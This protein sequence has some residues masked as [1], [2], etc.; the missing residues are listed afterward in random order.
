[1]TSIN[2]PAG[3]TS[4]GN[5]AFAN[6]SGLISLTNM[7]PQPV[8]INNNVFE[9]VNQSECELK[10]PTSSVNAYQNANVW[11][12]FY[13]IGENYTI[14]VIA[15]KGNV[16][17]GGMYN[18]NDSATLTAT[19]DL[20]YR[21]AGWTFRT[22]GGTPVSTANPFT[23]N[24]TIDTVI[25]A[26]FEAIAYGISYELNGGV[27]HADNPATYTVEDSV[28]LK[29]PTR[30][31]YEF[32][33]WAEGDTIVF[34]STGDRTFTAQWT[35]VNIFNIVYELNGG[36]NHSDNPE[37]YTVNDSVRLKAPTKA[38]YD[39]TGWAEG[40]RIVFGSTGDK[41]FTATWSLITYG[42][43]YELNG[44]VN[45]PDNPST[46][47]IEDSV[48]LKTP[49]KP[50][51]NFAG[52]AGDTIAF[53]GTGDKTLTAGWSAIVYNISY[54]LN[55]GVNHPD[56]PSTYTVED[57]VILKAPTKSGYNFAGWQGRDTLI[58]NGAGDKTFIAVWK[59]VVY[60]IIYEL[61]GGVNHTDNPAVYTIE[62]SVVMK[63]PVREGYSFAGWTGD[64]V[65][66]RGSTGDK[67]VTAQWSIITYSII[68]ELDGGTNH[69]ENPATY[70]VNDTVVIKAPTKP[71]YNFAGWHGSDTVI[72]NGTGDRTYTVLWKV[73]VY[74]IDYELDGGEN[75]VGNPA[76]YT[77]ED[78]VILQNPDRTGYEFTGWTEG[79]QIDRGSTGD[80][81][82]TATWKII[83]YSIIYELDGGVNHA[84]NP[85][86]CT[87]NDSVTLKAPSKE[88][89]VFDGWKEGGSIS[90]GSTGD[91]TFTA[92][93]KCIEA[94][95]EE[96]V[97]DG[98]DITE[99]ANDS[100][101]E[102]TV[103]ECDESSVS[104]D[105]GS[106]SQSN[107]TVNGETYA[108]GTEITLDGDLTTV[109]IQVESETGDSVKNYTLK[110]AAPI[111]SDNLY[112]QRWNDVIAVNRNPATNGGYSVS[113]VRWYSQNGSFAGAGEYITLSNAENVN[114]Y[115]S[116][117]KTEETASWHRVCAT[118]ETKSIEKVTAYPNPVPRGENITLHLP[119]RLVGSVLN[120]YSITGFLVKSGLPLPASVNSID[121]SSLDSGIYLL[122]ILNKDGNRHVIRII[123]E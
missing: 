16:T 50:G 103:K 20:G 87:V 24:V 90:K 109:N 7:N 93:W 64:S 81:T 17:G 118:E 63:Q 110:I 32:A 76:I 102:Y 69:P 96:I 38:G 72:I 34:G 56:N 116:E 57:T 120:I 101:F 117:V 1:L 71:G 100:V 78:T 35:E 94:N 3:I 14:T 11:K 62:D 30:T 67:S 119:D 68:C 115:Y 82:F 37:T 41:T 13:I 84:D 122:N 58:I 66:F 21:F 46:Y 53:G 112:Y 9:G 99:A 40:D 83:A 107:V 23:F 75:H 33:G 36:T 28:V 47:T 59:A 39:F 4:I 51:Y 86:V 6:C 111:N 121:V 22:A 74:S 80:R 27:N 113:D 54:D 105:L 73:L 43:S 92:Q 95:I 61:N 89:F 70:T 19:P 108:S 106:S 12:D 123:V 44:G 98:M 29:T 85:D 79:D 60:N 55:G 8:I 45:H 49:T 52:W 15:D 5:Y 88:G 104:L 48:I 97:I 65:I 2:I 42:I 26:N 31:G 91:R 114:D 18:A 10:V 77:V 25:Y